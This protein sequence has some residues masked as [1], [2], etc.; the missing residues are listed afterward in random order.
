MADNTPTGGNFGSPDPSL[1]FSAFFVA[2]LL[3]IWQYYTTD[4]VE[5]EK[6]RR[7]KDGKTTSHYSLA[8]HSKQFNKKEIIRVDDS[9][10]CAIGFGIANCILIEG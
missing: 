9:V 1:L 5:N 3:S 7:L 4:R 6:R 10:Y 8:E 2:L